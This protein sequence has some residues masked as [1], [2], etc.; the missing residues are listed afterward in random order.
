MT[1]RAGLLLIAGLGV[2]IAGCAMQSTEVP[3]DD[4]QT[5]AQTT[6]GDFNVKAVT[7]KRH[8]VPVPPEW[9]VPRDRLGWQDDAL[10]EGKPPIDINNPIP[11]PGPGIPR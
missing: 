10:N 6:K 9:N 3:G 7:G 5:A 8:A 2:W 1:N 11:N 4:D